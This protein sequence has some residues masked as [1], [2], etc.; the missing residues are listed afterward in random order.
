MEQIRAHPRTY[1]GTQTRAA[2]DNAQLYIC[3]QD[4][5]TKEA[6]NKISRYTQAYT[7]NGTTC[8]L[9]LLKLCIHKAHIDTNATTRLIKENLSKLDSKMAELNSNVFVFNLYVREQQEG[10]AARGQTTYH[11]LTN[12]FK[13]YMAT[14]DKKFT[15]YIKDIQI[16]YDDGDNITPEQLMLKAQNKYTTLVNSQ[17]WA[18]PDPNK[19]VILALKAELAK[20]KQ[21]QKVPKGKS[22]KKDKS[23]GKKSGKEKRKNK[24]QWMTQEPKEGEKK[25]KTVKNKLYHW[26]PNHKCWGRHKPEDCKGLGNKPKAKQQNPKRQSK[27]DKLIRALQAIQE[28]SE[29]EEE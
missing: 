1:L 26:C 24:L 11:L 27:K 2:Q 17:Q 28:E 21:Q 10:L 4:S 15:K 5:M 16:T 25:T 12:L 9:F 29:S 18:Q 20:L 13:G 7:L 3:I 23:S 8:G 19:A 22:G 14:S 6:M